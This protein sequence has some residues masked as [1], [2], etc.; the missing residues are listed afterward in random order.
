MYGKLKNG[1]LLYAPSSVMVN[2]KRIINPS[3]EIL[4][5]LGWLPVVMTPC[6]QT[7]EGYTAAA[8]FEETT[9][10]IVQVWTIVETPFAAPTTEERL[11]ALENAV[12]E[13]I[14]GGAQ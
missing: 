4:R 6:P 11:A 1:A 10:G 3:D 9:D 12:L 13:I 5:S 2:D 7:E 8:H 14:L